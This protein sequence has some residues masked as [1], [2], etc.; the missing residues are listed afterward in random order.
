MMMCPT[1][2]ISF[3]FY[4]LYENCNIW[5]LFPSLFELVRVLDFWLK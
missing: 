4:T 3:L 2:I 1:K 5:Y